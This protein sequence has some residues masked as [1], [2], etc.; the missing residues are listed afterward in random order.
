ML[1][2]LQASLQQYMNHELP[3]V[4]AGFRKGRGKLPE[5]KLP[6]SVGIQIKQENSRKNIYFWSVDYAKAI[7][8]V[9]HNKL[10]KIL[11][12]MG[13]PDHLTWLLR[14]LYAGQ[15][16]TEPDMEQQTGSK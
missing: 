13:I 11:K 8:C 5:I 16:P 15:E 3:D 14:N 7:D 9:D 10:W 4:Q 12:E 6:K 2:I 1:K